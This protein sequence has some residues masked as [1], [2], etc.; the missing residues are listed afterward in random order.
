MSTTAQVV[1]M[2]PKVQVACIIIGAVLLLR[3]VRGI[4]YVY[5]P[6]AV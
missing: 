4:S 3:G 5:I 6:P 1:P 2:N